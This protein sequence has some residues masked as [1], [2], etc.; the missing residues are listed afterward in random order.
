MVLRLKTRESRSL[1]GLPNAHSF[2]FT[3]FSGFG[4]LCFDAGWSSPVARQAHNL[5]AAGSNPA[6]ATKSNPSG[7]PGGFFRFQARPCLN[8]SQMLRGHPEPGMTSRRTRTRI[9]RA[10]TYRL[11][12]DALPA[13]AAEWGEFVACWPDDP[14]GLPDYPSLHVIARHAIAALRGGDRRI[15]NVVKRVLGEGDAIARELMRSGLL[16]DLARAFE[17]DVEVQ[18]LLRRR[19][20]RDSAPG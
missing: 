13:L 5:K 12:L 9:D 20:G 11:L 1:P 6:P 10:E 7:I 2:S 18:R 4:R 3:I 19:I 8:G 15:L 17:D 14:R 16:V